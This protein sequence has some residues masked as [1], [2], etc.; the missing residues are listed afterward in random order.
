MSKEK[1]IE[2]MAKTEC[3][4]CKKHAI[5]NLPIISNCDV[6][7][8]CFS[9]LIADMGNDCKEIVIVHDAKAFGIPINYCPICGRELK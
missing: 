2:E 5:E 4:F 6:L 7:S 8:E 1:Q 9:A 3:V